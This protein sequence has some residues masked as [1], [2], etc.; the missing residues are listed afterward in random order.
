MISID[1]GKLIVRSFGQLLKQSSGI[2]VIDIPVNVTVSRLRQ[3]LKQEKPRD[4]N[5]EGNNIE[6]MCDSKNA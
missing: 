5:D 3:F 2:S 6:M 1:D 4:F